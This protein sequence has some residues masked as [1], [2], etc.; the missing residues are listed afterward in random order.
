M[1]PCPPSLTLTILTCGGAGRRWARCASRRREEGVSL[2]ARQRRAGLAKGTLMGTCC[3]HHPQSPAAACRDPCAV[4]CCA[5]LC[6]AVLCCA[7]L[8]CAV[9]CCAV[10][11]V[12]EPR[13]G[14]CPRAAHL[15][16]VPRGARHHHHVVVR[17][18]QAV[19][20]SQHHR[21]LQ[22]RLARCAREG[23]GGKGGWAAGGRSSPDAQKAVFVPHTGSCLA[24]GRP[25]GA[26]HSR[27]RVQR[28][29]RQAGGQ[30]SRQA[31]RQGAARHWG[32]TSARAGS[33]GTTF[34]AASYAHRWA[35]APPAP[36]AARW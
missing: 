29:A 17:L 8:C 13:R 23:A 26:Y 24:Q 2:R 18:H 25:T 4:P 34:I 5:V 10:Q 20:G 3:W 14:P 36:A 30:V 35:W 12:G 1:M 16:L 31:R 27:A 33:L 15:E 28:T 21:L 7:V 19:G 22:Q 32:C 9:L 11:K 6:C